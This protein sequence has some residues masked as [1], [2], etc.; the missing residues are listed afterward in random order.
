MKPS[1]MRSGSKTQTY[2]R[3]IQIISSGHSLGGFLSIMSAAVVFNNSVFKYP[4]T[5]QKAT[6]ITFNSWFPPEVLD[7]SSLEET[8]FFW[9]ILGMRKVVTNANNSQGVLEY[10]V[11]IINYG[12]TCAF[13]FGICND[14]AE[15]TLIPCC[16]N[17]KNLPA[18]CTALKGG[19]ASYA[20]AIKGPFY[21]YLLSTWPSYSANPVVWANC[22]SVHN[23][24]GVDI[25][26]KLEDF[27]ISHASLYDDLPKNINI[28]TKYLDMLFTEL[29]KRD[30]N[31]KCKPNDRETKP[32]LECGV[33]IYSNIILGGYYRMPVDL[34]FNNQVITI[35]WN[36]RKTNVNVDIKPD[37]IVPLP[38]PIEV[39]RGIN[40]NRNL[41]RVEQPLR[42]EN[43]T[44]TNVSSVA[45][46]SPRSPGDD[47]FFDARDAG[48]GK[49]YKTV[50]KRTSKKLRKRRSKR[51]TKKLRK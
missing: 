25:E 46:G 32:N 11:P 3:N 31:R 34:P 6:S 48:G 12:T 39:A 21:Y 44:S 18:R 36:D 22:H 4:N 49:K 13:A 27:S 17:I 7:I 5:F 33:T 29:N 1:H 38:V 23:F 26:R 47:E 15:R 50:V 20:N 40:A 37:K 28:D 2:A 8:N 30:N 10:Y 9:K 51:S 14:F 45:P 43:P 16:S 24:Y 35:R 41:G 19:Y 42:L